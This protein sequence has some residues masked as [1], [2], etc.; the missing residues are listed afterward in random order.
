MKRLF[1]V[2]TEVELVCWAESEEEARW[3]GHRYAREELS[4]QDRMDDAT[5]ITRE[6]DV[7]PEWRDAIP[8][9]EPPEDEEGTEWTDMQAGPA[10]R[11]LGEKMLTEKREAEFMAKQGT[12]SFG[13]TKG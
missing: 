9:G 8:Y 10:A 1:V 5:P 12:L 4:N 6:R 2:T 13:E 11:M 3:E 7:P